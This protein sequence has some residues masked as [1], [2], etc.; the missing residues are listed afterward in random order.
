VFTF[1]PQGGSAAAAAGEKASSFGGS[2]RLL[3]KLH[4][5]KAGISFV[6]SLKLGD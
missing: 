1:S 6:S 4:A 5:V 3:K 2:P